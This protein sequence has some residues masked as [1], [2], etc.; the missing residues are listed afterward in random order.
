MDSTKYAL[1]VKQGT[2]G[3]FKRCKKSMPYSFDAPSSIEYHFNLTTRGY[4]ALVFSGDHDIWIPFLSTHAWIRSFNFSIVDDWRAWHLGG[5][6]GGFAITYANHM[7]FATLK[8][9]G[10]SAIEYPP[11]ESL[12]MAQR[13][14]DNK[15]L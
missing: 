9:G 12:A 6:A 1:G 15:P 14:L 4:R 8:G 2:I 13:W 5:Q 11:R 7:T 3:E 10:H